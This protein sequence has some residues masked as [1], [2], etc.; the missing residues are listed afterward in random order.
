MVFYWYHKSGGE[1]VVNFVL[2]IDG[3]GTSCRAALATADGIV[4]GRAKSGAANIRTDLTGARTNISEAARRAFVEAGQAPELLSQTPAVLGLAGANVG[5]Y[6]QQ[7]QAI[8]PFSQSRVETDAEIALEGAVGPDDGAMAILGTGTAY[9]VRRKGKARA[10]GGWGFQIGD[11]GGGGRIGRDLLE[12]T[13]LAHDGIRTGSPLTE[14]MLAV[15]R[16]RPE[17]V[18]EFTTNAKPGDFGGFAPKVF[19]HAAKGD[20][21]ATWI[22]EKAVADVEAALAA[23]DLADDAPLCLLGGLAPLYA[24]RLSARYRA[25][26]REPLGDALSGAV[27]MA[28]RAFANPAGAAHG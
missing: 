13:L 6:R 11:Q 14:E 23:L 27:Q 18:V 21:V 7:L 5:T 2:G 24:P 8:L 17:D 15:F 1:T 12:Q 3:G 20:A 25:L 16:N 22:V 9:M 19:E 10:I 4:V 26:L 28:V